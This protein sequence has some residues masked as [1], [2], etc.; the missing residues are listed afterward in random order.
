MIELR[1]KVALVTGGSRGLGFILARDLARSGCRVVICARN[2]AELENAQ[3]QL[4]SAGAEVLAIP[5]DVSDRGQV[6][7]M[8]VEITQQYGRI[9]LLFNN[10]GVIQVGPIEAQ[11]VA[12]FEEAMNT[13]FWGVLYPTLAVLPQMRARREGNIV[14]ITSIGGKVSVPHLLPYCCAKFAAVGFSEGL[15]AELA[16]Q[17]IAVTTV[18]PG[19]MRTGSFLNAVFKGNQA[20]EYTVFSLAA[21]IPGVSMNAERASAQ[22]IEAA[23]RGDAEKILSAPADLLARFHGLFPGVTADLLGVVNRFLPTASGPTGKSLGKTLDPEMAS[24]AFTTLTTLG[25]SAARRFHER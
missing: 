11:T 23:R 3:R 2:W 13:M 12:D 20:A 7:R 18:A 8:V 25:R 24:R 5:C 15:H 21:N 19:L 10:A 16:D 22:I 9:D 17:G 14:N 6:D 4:R 1:G